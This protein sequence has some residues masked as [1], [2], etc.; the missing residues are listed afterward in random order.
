M[1]VILMIKVANEFRYGR[2]PDTQVG[3]IERKTKAE[4]K[5]VT[6]EREPFTEFGWLQVK[7]LAGMHEAEG[8]K[9]VELSA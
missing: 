4:L 7:R 5:T 2:F 1:T 8:L 6:I 9:T 3:M